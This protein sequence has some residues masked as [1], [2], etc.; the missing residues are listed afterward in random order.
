MSA[1]ANIPAATAATGDRE[2]GGQSPLRVA[3]PRVQAE[4]RASPTE[5]TT[6]RPGSLGGRRLAELEVQE[7]EE[8][9]GTGLGA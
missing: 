1:V 4:R 3:E 7:D 8:P 2:C 5:L 9:K 6:R